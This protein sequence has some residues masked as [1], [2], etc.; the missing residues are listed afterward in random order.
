MG[1]THDNRS[2]SKITAWQKVI[3]FK[4]FLSEGIREPRSRDTSLRMRATQWSLCRRLRSVAKI[5]FRVDTRPETDT[6]YLQI[7]SLFF[8]FFKNQ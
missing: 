4:S 7:F 5:E 8:P 1:T 6:I 3:V 2:V